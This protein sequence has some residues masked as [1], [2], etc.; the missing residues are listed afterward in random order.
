[1]TSVLR[2]FFFL[3]SVFFVVSDAFP[4]TMMKGGR[5][6]L[7]ASEWK[8]EWVTDSRA[9]VAYDSLLY[10]DNPAPLFR[11]EFLVNG[12]VRKATLYITGIGYYEASI[13]GMKVGDHYLDPG[14]TDYRK[15]VPYNVFDVT[16]RLRS[17]RCCLGVELG[18]GWYNPLPLLMWGGLNIRK[19]VAT[20]T[21]RLF[22]RLEVEYADGHRQVVVSDG[23]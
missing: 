4:Q 8:A 7:P 6:S 16:T 20:G 14:W 11:K 2:I 5:S 21:P 10:Q 3:L 13:N 17:G 19:F 1:M 12:A 22:A 18:N 9:A 15:T 23:S